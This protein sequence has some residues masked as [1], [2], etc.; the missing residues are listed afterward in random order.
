[1]FNNKSINMKKVL[2]LLL[3]ALTFT[4][5]YSLPISSVEDEIVNVVVDNDIGDVIMVGI[6][7]P[8]VVLHLNL[9]DVSED[10]L[11]KNLASLGEVVLEN[12]FEL[13]K[14][15]SYFLPD[16]YRRFE[17]RDT[18]ANKF[19]LRTKRIDGTSGGNPGLC[20]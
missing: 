10:V 7:V 5:G 18:T 15:A 3:F 16:L 20:G 11:D 19:I 4:T 1:M 8:S 2:V 6:D 12:V 13:D 17:N 9:F 14:S